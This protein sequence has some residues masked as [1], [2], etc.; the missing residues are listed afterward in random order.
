M[1]NTL[2]KLVLFSLAFLTAASANAIDITRVEPANWWVGMKNT[3]LQIMVY[4]PN[5]GHSTVTLNYPGVTLKEVARV[6]NPNYVFIYINIAKNAKPGILPLNF[7]E[8][9]EKSVYQYP[10]K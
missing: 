3:E 2:S 9:Q 8:G 7:K 4:G 6:E 10:L 1:H 5:V